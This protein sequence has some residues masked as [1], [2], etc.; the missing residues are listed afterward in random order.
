M[1]GPRLTF[2]DARL[3]L[4]YDYEA[5]S[6][7]YKWSRVE[8]TGV[9]AVSFTAYESCDVQQVD[10]YGKLLELSESSW[11]ERLRQTHF[12]TMDN[13]DL[14]HYRIFLDEV[15]CYEVAATG[16]RAEPLAVPPMT[17]PAVR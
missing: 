9:R 3:I 12:A 2:A 4:E 15:G 14:R 5:Q 1:D 8:F 13:A 7:G 6:G 11:I 10:A 16:F 17:P